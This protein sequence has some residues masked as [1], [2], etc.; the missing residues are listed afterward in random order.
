MTRYYVT[1]TIKT[2]DDFETGS[3]DYSGHGHATRWEAEIERKRAEKDPMIIG[4][5]I[6]EREETR[7]TSQPLHN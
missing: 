1:V 3:G 7:W 5:Y 2:G 4:A 6:E